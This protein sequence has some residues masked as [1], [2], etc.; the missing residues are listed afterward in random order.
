M[1]DKLKRWMQAMGGTSN[2]LFHERFVAG[3]LAGAVAQSFV[4]PIEVVKTRL[5]LSARTSSQNAPRA[6]GQ[7]TLTGGIWDCAQKL[8]KYI[9]F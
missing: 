4:Y 1:Y 8:Y 2:S 5:T 6:F 7:C 9:Y 3:A